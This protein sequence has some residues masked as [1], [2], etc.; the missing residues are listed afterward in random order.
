V[1]RRSCDRRRIS[2]PTIILSADD[3]PPDLPVPFL[4]EASGADPVARS[5][6]RTEETRK[7]TKK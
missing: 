2:S 1:S 5:G 4:A 6:S 3:L 7:G